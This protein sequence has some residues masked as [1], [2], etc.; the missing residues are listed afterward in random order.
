MK[1]NKSFLYFFIGIFAFGKAANLT[2][3]TRLLQT[4]L[5]D[6]NTDAR[7]VTSSSQQATVSLAMY[8]LRFHEINT[9]LQYI[10]V[11]GYV[12]AEWKDERLTWNSSEYGGLDYIAIAPSKLWLPNIAL[13]NFYFCLNLVV[14]L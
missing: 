3:E 6:Y 2:D 8:L 13:G 14:I 1:K 10:S 12:T 9:Q 11:V 4:L 7:P 5:T